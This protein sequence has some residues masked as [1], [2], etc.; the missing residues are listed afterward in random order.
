MTQAA[1][2][3]GS[4]MLRHPRAA[5]VRPLALVLLVVVTAFG[6]AGLLRADPQAAARHWMAHLHVLPIVLAC[7]LCDRVAECTAWL[8]VYDRFGITSWRWPAVCAFFA[9]RAGLP[10]PAQLGRL[11]PPDAMARHGF[12]P[13]DQCLKAEASAFALNTAAVGGLIVVLLVAKLAGLWAGVMGGLG[14]LLALRAIALAGGSLLEGTRFAVPG[15]FL[16]SRSAMCIVVIQM[17]GWAAH[18]TALWIM[19]RMLAD[20]ITWQDTALYACAAAILGAGSG[21]PGGIG[22]TEG[23]LGVSLTIMKIPAEH[24]VIAIASF[25]LVTFWVWIPIGWIALLL[26]NARV[27]ARARTTSLSIGVMP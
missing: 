7:V 12:G 4:S 18:G 24:L 2:Q 8:W 13:A 1:T 14:V 16:R 21:L 25:R 3:P 10:L 19:I 9:G 17:V 11:I 23:L 5:L 22:A 27:R 6:V 20:N 26:T 15:D